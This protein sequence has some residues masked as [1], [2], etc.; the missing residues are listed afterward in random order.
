MLS[1]SDRQ[2][3]TIMDAA[4]AI[5]PDRRDVYLQR[6]EAMLRLRRR[7]D[8]RDVTEIAALATCGLVHQHIDRLCLAHRDE[9]MTSDHV[10]RRYLDLIL[11]RRD[12]VLSAAG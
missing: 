6:I 10:R 11:T 2:L 4:R 12:A 1:L 5:G 9:L 7:F 8:D 3:Q